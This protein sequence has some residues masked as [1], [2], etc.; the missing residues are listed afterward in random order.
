LVAAEAGQ[1][2]AEL[3]QLWVEAGQPLAG[4]QQPWV[5]AGQPLAELQVAAAQLSFVAPSTE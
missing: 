1:L 3:P 4:L 2:L 5:E